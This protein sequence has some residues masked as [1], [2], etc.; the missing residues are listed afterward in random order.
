VGASFS[1]IRCRSYGACREVDRMAIKIWLLRSQVIGPPSILHRAFRDLRLSKSRFVYRSG[2]LKQCSHRL[3]LNRLVKP[4]GR[5]RPR[6]P[7]ETAHQFPNQTAPV[8][9]NR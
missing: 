3:G 2:P 6:R 5:Q 4:S 8:I 1:L 9:L 7:I